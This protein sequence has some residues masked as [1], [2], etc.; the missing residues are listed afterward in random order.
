MIL[1]AISHKSS[2]KSAIKK[3]IAYVFNPEKMMDTRYDRDAVMGKQFIRGYDQSKW[4]T[5]FKDN[6]NNRTFEHSKR[7]VLRHEIISFH[8]YSD[9]FLDE[10]TLKAFGRFYLQN[11]SS[12][13]LGVFAVHYDEAPHIHFIISAVDIHGNSTRI[14]QQEFKDFKN[15]L[16]TFQMEFYPK[17]E[18]SVVDH[19]KS[20]TLKLKLSHQ[21]QRMEQRGVTSKKR[22]LSEKV[23]ELAKGC[24]SLEALTS[25]LTSNS[26]KPYYRKGKLTGVWM[27]KTKYRLITLGV[28]KEH[29]KQMTL[30]QK[31]LDSLRNSQKSIERDGLDWEH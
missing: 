7:T 8:Q 20:Q 5:A 10:K 12:N 28:G 4:V 1:K 31:R 9:P 24:E 23:M 21:E 16:Q 18:H 2:S 25:L 6:D 27:G 19:N 14:S 26:L 17:L 11:R 3:L 30:E 29:L 22:L 15:Q 13:S